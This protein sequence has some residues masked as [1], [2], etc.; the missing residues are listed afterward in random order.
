MKSHTKI[1]LFINIGYEAVKDL[2]G[3]GIN[4]VNALYIIINRVNEYIEE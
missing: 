3:V 2:S 4:R 1:F